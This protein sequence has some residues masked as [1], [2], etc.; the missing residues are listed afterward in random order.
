MARS[1][2]RGLDPDRAFALLSNERRRHVL[3][4]LAQ[5]DEELPLQTVATEVIARLDDVDPDAVDDSTYRSV[6]VSLYQNHL[7]QLAEAGVIHY[8]ED[9]R[10]VR[11]AH[12]RRT[13]ELLRLAGVETRR[14]WGR[15]Y[16]LLTGA[17]L[18]AG[19]L[20]FGGLIRGLPEPWVLPA[21]VLVG[22]LTLI[23]GYQYYTRNRI[24]VTDW[25]VLA[26]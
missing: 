11:I 20:S 17:T 13:W 5:R 21:V 23:G 25:G 1:E 4:L 22:G 6:Y 24:E 26:E 19:A 7:P 2:Q 16:A 8:D 10:T 14:S 15:A 18:L 9:E 3:C 12:T